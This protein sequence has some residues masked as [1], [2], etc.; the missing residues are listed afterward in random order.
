MGSRIS[1]VGLS[2]S[3]WPGLS[4][5]ST[6]C[7]LKLPKKGVDARDKRGHDSEVVAVDGGGPSPDRVP[8]APS[9]RPCRPPRHPAQNAG[10]PPSRPRPAGPHL[11]YR[12]RPP[13]LRTTAEKPAPH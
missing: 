12:P 1:T 2:S 11:G 4:R 6:P 5:P 3:S 7:L 8:P 13:R 10:R 9:P